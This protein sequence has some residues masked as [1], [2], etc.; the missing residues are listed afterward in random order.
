MN[1]SY[2]RR[3]ILGNG[4][5]N[6]QSGI[7]ASIGKPANFSTQSRLNKTKKNKILI[8]NCNSRSHTDKH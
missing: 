6:K 4:Y 7:I 2:M 8:Q 1:V 3:I 5:T